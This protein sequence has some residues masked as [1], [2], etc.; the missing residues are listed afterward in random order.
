MNNRAFKK[1]N[2]VDLSYNLSSKVMKIPTESSRLCGSYTWAFLQIEL[3]DDKDLPFIT[4]SNT[5]LHEYIHFIQNLSTIDM[6]GNDII[7][8]ADLVTSVTYSYG[9]Q[10]GK[11]V[12]ITTQTRSQGGNSAVISVKKQSIDGLENWQTNL[13]G[14]TTHAKL[15]RLGDGNIRQTVTNPDGTKVVTNSNNGKVITVQSIGADNTSGITVAYTYDEFN[16]QAGMTQTE[17][18]T[19]FTTS[20]MTYNAAGQPLT[21][22]VNGRT[23]RIVYNVV[24]RTR[25]ITLPGDRTVIEVYHPTGELQR[26]SGADTY[27]QEWTY[28]PVWGQ[29]ATLTTYKDSDTPQVTTWIYN[30][31]G[32][33]ASKKYPNNNGPSY[34]YNADGNLLTRTWERNITTSYTYDNAGRLLTQSYSDNT[35]GIT[36]TYDYLDRIVSLTDASGTRNFTYNAQHLLVNETIPHIMNLQSSFTYDNFG[37]RTSRTL[38]LNNTTIASAGRSYDTFGR[39]AS[40]SNGTDT[41]SYT[42]RPG[43]QLSLSGWTNGQDSAMSNQSYEYD[44]YN[45]LISIKLNNVNEVSYTLNAKDQRTAATYA[46]AGLW[47]FTYDDKGQVTGA[48]GSSKSYAYSY[49]GI[50]NRLTANENSAVTNYTSNLL[51]QYTLINNTAPEYD[52]DGNMTTSGNGW[53]YTYNGENRITQATKGSTTVTMAYDYAGR[54]IS[55]TVTASGIVQNAYKYVYDGFKLIAVY[56]NNDLVMTFTWQPESL[57]MDVPVSMTYGG[58]AYYYVTDGNKN[59]TALLD[60]SGN[61]VAEYVYGPFGQTVSATGSI[62]QINPFRFS[63][64]F[65]DDET[66][67]VYYNYRYYSPELGRWTKRDPIGETGGN[68]LYS[69]INNFIKH[70]DQNGLILIAFDGTRNIESDYTNVYLMYLAY[71]YLDKKAYIRG[72]GNSIE[73]SA[74]KGYY[75]AAKA[76]T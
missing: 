11:T 40:I 42:Y 5:F 43:G 2:L 75:K 49:D 55:K 7:D 56:N 6:N 12:S 76:A 35:P 22:T 24:N 39:I 67:L 44:Q 51:N 61:R 53:V 47:N 15:E 4:I 21:Q 60:A 38:Q 23:T 10:N 63:S 31:R 50:G 29:K 9:T 68:N 66:G 74:L 73:N 18:G 70:Y 46:N 58:A 41:L 57:G 28:D 25:T 20:S 36:A 59:V 45:R 27:T 26:V 1:V 34:T 16:R 71:L 32:N 64:E 17:N 62:A 3:E 54:R 30:S 48:N 33:L 65:H 14:L 72:I 8:D 37:R 19:T 69:N 52:A 13:N